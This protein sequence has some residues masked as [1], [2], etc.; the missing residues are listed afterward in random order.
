V[1]EPTRDAL[2]QPVDPA[3]PAA[4]IPPVPAA[5]RAA[6]AG[7][8]SPAEELRELLSAR[9]GEAH[10]VA[11]QDYPDPDAIS[12]ALAYRELARCFEIETDILYEG[13]ISHP[14]NLALVNLL[15]IDLTTYSE[16]YALERYNAAVF[17]DNQGTTT[18]LTGRLREAGVPTL[19]V[20]DHHDPQDLLD[21]IFSDI[22][23][24]G[25]AA[26][27]MTEYL[28]SGTFFEMDATNAQHSHLATALMHGLHSETNGFV[29]AGRAEYEA[30]A[31]LCGLLDAD[32]LERVLCVQ[33]SR[34]TMDVI[35]TALARRIIRGGLS[36][37]GVGYVRWADRDAVPQAADFLL[38]EENVHSAIVY[39]IVRGED[40]R[41]IVSGSLRTT[42]ATMG[43]D[44]FLK[45]ALGKDIRGKPFGGGRS[46]AGGFE[47]DLGF[48]ASA[49]GDRKER[50]AKWALFDR[51]IRRKLFYAAGLENDKGDED[52]LVVREDSELAID[53]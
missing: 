45:K 48:L 46:R 18:R 19:A 40:G 43:V 24:I 14:E 8:P 33:K 31:F 16:G 15:E 28:S 39:G 25:A 27:I 29:L 35:Q 12:S 53:E 3:I 47:I 30:G 5:D 11:I 9:R 37:A 49:N 52:E 32:L 51:Q 13:L 17:V 7:G 36:V 50:E 23:I 6:R 10:V 20:I 34:G 4:E 22:R 26:T 41:E 42:N 21:P 44:A 1:Q 38:T 2:T